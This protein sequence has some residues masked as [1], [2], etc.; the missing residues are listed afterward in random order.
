MAQND[1]IR[2]KNGKV[3]VVLGANMAR[4]LV[5]LDNVPTVGSELQI[6]FDAIVSTPEGSPLG[7]WLDGVLVKIVSVI[8]VPGCGY[9]CGIQVN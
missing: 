5:R 4:T 2:D 3:C 6:T 9:L 7:P 8:P 1:D